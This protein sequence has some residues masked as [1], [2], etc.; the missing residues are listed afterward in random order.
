MVDEERCCGEGGAQG[1]VRGVD[2]ESPEGVPEFVLFQGFREI[3]ERVER[4]S[5]KDARG[6]GDGELEAGIP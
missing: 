2:G 4:A 3:G 5:D 6:G 1:D